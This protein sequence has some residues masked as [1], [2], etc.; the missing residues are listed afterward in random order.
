MQTIQEIYHQTL[1]SLSLS[2]RFQL[3]T[4]LLKDIPP[5]SIVDYRE[6]WSEEDYTDFTKAGND[7]INQRLEEEV[8]AL[9]GKQSLALAS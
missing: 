1:Q 8:N 7:Y 4:L 5:L 9:Q 6:E 3:A 2:E